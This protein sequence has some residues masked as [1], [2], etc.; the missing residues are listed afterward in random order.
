MEKI[1]IKGSDIKNFIGSWRLD[2]NDI[3]NETIS[4]FNKN[5]ERQN[6]SVDSS[7]KINKKKKIF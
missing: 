5:H 4:F 3:I 2:N 6:P 7:G 1:N